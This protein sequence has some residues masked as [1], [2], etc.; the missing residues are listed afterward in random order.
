[1]DWTAHVDESGDD[2]KYDMILGRDLLE[3]L[4]MT[5]N[6][7]D[8][9]VIWDNAT[10]QMKSPDFVQKPLNNYDTDNFYWHNDLLE[11]DALVSAT[12][13]L[14]KILDAKYEKADLEE[15][16]RSCS[17]L[18]SDDQRKLLSVLK[19]H[20]TLF[21]GTLGCWNGRDYDIELKP[22]VTPYHARPFPIPRI[23]EG[24]L[25][26]ELER[27]C[28]IGVLKKV[29]HSEW[30]VPTF[31]VPKKDGSVRFIS[32]LREINK[33]ILR[34]PYPIPH[35]QDLLLKLE[36]F[37]YATSLDLNMGYYHIVLSP[38]AR[39]ICT[40]VTPFGKYEYQRLPMGLCNSPDVFQERMSELMSGLEFVRA[41]IDDILVTTSATW[42]D[43]LEKLDEVLG[44]LA[45]AGLKVNAKNHFSE[46]RRPNILVSG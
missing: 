1:V 36:G 19:K 27:L 29:N 24:T 7:G 14:K 33:R 26:L 43:H 21:D 30:A 25:K 23:H 39:K 16:C 38:D 18:S 31:I 6:F 42:D 44:R 5:L 9:T 46:D 4:G 3:S 8:M 12:E 32:D 45:S 20:E 37:M 2:H 35:I 11:S 17:H 13:R 40:I 28:K 41:Y 34:K 10:V 22:G 15:I